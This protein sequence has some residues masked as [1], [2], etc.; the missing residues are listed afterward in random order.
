VLESLPGLLLVLMITI[1]LILLPHLN[2]ERI[3]E[4]RRATE[5]IHIKRDQG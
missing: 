4:P 2:D 5:E 3:N 1:T